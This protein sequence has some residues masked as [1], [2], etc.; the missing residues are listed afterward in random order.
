MFAEVYAATLTATVSSFSS[1]PLILVLASNQLKRLEEVFV[2][3][4]VTGAT[5]ALVILFQLLSLAG[6]GCL[7]FTIA[8][9]VVMAAASAAA[10]VAAH[11]K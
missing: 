4:L 7:S 10:I 5:Q 3:A 2:A 8:S 11:V 6:A 1:G 9:A